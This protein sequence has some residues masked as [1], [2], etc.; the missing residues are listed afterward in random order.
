MKLFTTK[1]L[2]SLLLLTACGNNNNGKKNTESSNPKP[3]EIAPQYSFKN[4]EKICADYDNISS[5]TIKFIHDFS[6]PVEFLYN[7]KVKS[8][9]VLND[10]T[11]DRKNAR[12]LAL[13]LSSRTKALKNTIIPNFLNTLM[14]DCKNKTYFLEP[15]LFD[16]N[17]KSHN[18]S[19]INLKN[20]VK[21]AHAKIT[22]ENFPLDK[23]RLELLKY[24]ENNIL[25]KLDTLEEIPL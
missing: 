7:I 5:I 2:L 12:E 4:F 23:E 19:I 8:I 24:F 14:K 6:S 11:E 1:Y 22:A 17:I 18:N 25:N 10:D 20:E 15:E 16:Y 13:N 21:T 3:Q 9:Y